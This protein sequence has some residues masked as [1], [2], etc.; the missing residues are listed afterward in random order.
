[1]AVYTILVN[2]GTDL[3]LDENVSFDLDA[4]KTRA[5][6]G[7]VDFV[8]VFITARGNS[9]K[10]SAALIMADIRGRTDEVLSEFT[11]KRI[12]IQRDGVDEYDFQASTSLEGTP[13]IES[14]RTLPESGQGESHYRYELGIYVKLP[15][16][17]FS[18]AKKIRTSI[19]TFKNVKGEFVE[20]I[21]RALVE[22][23]TFQLANSTARS[24]KPSSTDITE[25]RII[26][27]NDAV[28]EYVWRWE[29]RQK[30]KGKKIISVTE[31]IRT[32]GDGDDFVPDTQVLASGKPTKPILHQAVG[33]ETIIVIEGVTLALTDKIKPPAQHYTP[34]A[35]LK[36]AAAREVKGK[37][38]LVSIEDGTFQLPWMEVWLFTGKGAVPE[39]RHGD[40]QNV[41]IDIPPADGSAPGSA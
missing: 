20:K 11:A 29:A 14:F 33:V 41:L 24:F 34:S 21:W 22:H 28:A 26:Q 36:R 37:V 12:Q 38:T 25:R 2:G 30:T 19:E 16:N 6:S 17:A 8:E 27:F 4:V 1:M 5:N 39:P 31:T 23:R 40:H 35:D 13:V 10:S 15:G 32:T 18:G 7:R 9:K 3:T